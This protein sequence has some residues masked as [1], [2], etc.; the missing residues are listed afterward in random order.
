MTRK[1]PSRAERYFTTGISM[2]TSQG[3]NGPNV[4]AAEWAM[5]ISYEPVLIAVFVHEGSQT[6]KNISMTKEFGVNMAS[7]KQTAQVSIA[8]GYS[9]AEINKLELKG[10][11]KT[12]KPKKINAP[13]LAGCTINAECSL[14]RKEKI[15]DHVMLVGKVVHMKHDDS[16][17]PLLYHGGRYFGMGGKIEPEREEVLVDKDVFEFFKCLA[18]NRFVLKCT[19][20]VVRSKNKVLVIRH[21]HTS[22][23]TIPLCFS[24]AG[25]NQRDHLVREMQNMKLGIQV[26][27]R[28][29]LKRLV[30]RHND[31]VQR[32]NLLLF[33]GKSKSAK[34]NLWKPEND[35][36]ISRL[37]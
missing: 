8:G 35:G 24:P 17:S 14:M 20:V 11:F 37:V 4:M 12:L 18:D 22:L 10:V 13:M 23:E 28:P 6:L 34:D 25:K 29:S 1:V 19:G 16:K 15:G 7:S 3:P 9:G 27:T 26:G 2:V 32:V 31:K 33:D 36:F 21:S 5:Q 30:L